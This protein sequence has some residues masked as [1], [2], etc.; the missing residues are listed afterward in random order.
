MHYDSNQKVTK[1]GFECKLSLLSF[2]TICKDILQIWLHVFQYTIAGY[3]KLNVA[4]HGYTGLYM[5]TCVSIWY[6]ILKQTLT[7]CE[8]MVIIIWTPLTDGKASYEAGLR[9]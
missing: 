5:A 3:T 2:Y 6:L 9:V 8:I 1:G 7:K 4:I